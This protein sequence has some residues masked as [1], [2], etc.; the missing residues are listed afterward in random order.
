MPLCSQETASASLRGLRRYDLFDGGRRRAG[1]RESDAQV[2]QAKENLARVTEEVELRLQVAY[3]K[4]ERTKEMVQI[5][6]ELAA[7]RA[8]TAASP[9]NGFKKVRPCGR[10]RTAFSLRNLMSR[11]LLLQLQLDYIQARDELIE[12]MGQSSINCAGFWPLTAERRM[13]ESEKMTELSWM[14]NPSVVVRGS[15]TG[16]TQEI[17]AGRHHFSADEPVT[18]GGQDVGPTPYDLLLAAL[19]ACT[20]MTVG[21][22]ARRKNW[23]LDGVVVRLRHSKIHAE[24]CM[25]CER[26]AGILDRIESELEF[27][28]PLTAEQRA[29]LLEIAEK[30]PVHRTLKSEIDIRTWLA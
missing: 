27:L 5:S 28:G 21:M 4:L 23:P 14:P 25:A 7:L 26:E 24:D 15:G 22:Y 2:A 29:Q 10:R 3:N 11:H 19:G 9:R 6:Q 16:F 17:V 20:S 1:L 13:N 12:A 30:C 18:S 8:E